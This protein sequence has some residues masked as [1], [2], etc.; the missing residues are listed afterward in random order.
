MRT[1]YVQT[2][3]LVLVIFCLMVLQ[4]TGNANSPLYGMLL[5]ISGP[6]L[7]AILTTQAIRATNAE[8]NVN[9]SEHPSTENPYT[10]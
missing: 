6:A 7:A 3:V 4:M 8:N 10:K 9:S 2:L 1:L 5:T